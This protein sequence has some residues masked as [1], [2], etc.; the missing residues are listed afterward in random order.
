MLTACQSAV[1][2]YRLYRV[3][4]LKFVNIVEKGQNKTT[5]WICE[6]KHKTPCVHMNQ[7]KILLT[8]QTF[9]SSRY[10]M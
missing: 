5:T 2:L 3:K 10:G 9:F 7:R 8:D 1:E 6:I 4:N